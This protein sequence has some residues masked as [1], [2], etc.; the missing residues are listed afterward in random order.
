[1]NIIDLSSTIENC[2]IS[3]VDQIEIEYQD[4]QAGAQA[5]KNM[6][7]VP[8]NLLR[9][10]EGWAVETIRNLSTHGST[11]VDAPYHYNSTIQG[12]PAQTIDELPLDW[13]FR[14]GVKLDMRHKADGDAVTVEDIQAQLATI[15]YTLAPN[16][17]VLIENGCDQYYG[18]PDYMAH[19]CGVSADATHWLYEQ[20]I[21]VMGIDAWG[22]D[23]PLHLQAQDAL[24]RNQPGIFWEAHQAN[25][26]YS[27]IERLVNLD[28][29]PPTGF[30]IACFP[31]KIKGASGAPARVVAILSA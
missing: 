26:A 31:L 9:D 11:H 7:G 16:D 14:P 27:Q 2:N 8:E 25:L 24:E 1:M 4:H 17:I 20:G 23:S 13:F 10:G 18:Q 3:P 19:G 15:K 6:M 22:W 28:K 30:T 12:K 5:I 29:L 21:R